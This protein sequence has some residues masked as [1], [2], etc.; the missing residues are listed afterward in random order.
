M[1]E[2]KDVAILQAALAVCALIIG[3]LLAALLWFIRLDRKAFFDKLRDHEKCLDDL[4]AETDA[5]NGVVF[6]VNGGDGVNRWENRVRNLLQPIT[7]EV[8]TT[9]TNLRNLAL[10]LARALP[11]IDLSDL[12]L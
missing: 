3:G 5:L 4:R 8:Q 6:G 11:N 2:V 9:A 7:T 1:N 12:R 10:V